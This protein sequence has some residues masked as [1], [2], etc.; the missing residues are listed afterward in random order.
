ML[1]LLLVGLLPIAWLF[2]FSSSSLL[3]ATWLHV[4]AWA[5]A[6]WFGWRLLKLAFPHTPTRRV[7]LLW[8]V[9]FAIVSF[10]MTTI[11]RPVL[12]RAEGQPFIESAKLFFLEHLGSLS[13]SDVIKK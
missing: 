5:V 12:Y 11:L 1:G 7:S 10:Q 6:L 13:S 9:L 3:F 2:S 8:T 4:V